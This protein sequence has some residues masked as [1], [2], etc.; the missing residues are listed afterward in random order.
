MCKFFICKFVY[1][2][3]IVVSPYQTMTFS[4]PGMGKM[5]DPKIREELNAML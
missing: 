3:F 2:Y 5:P 4:T 1:M